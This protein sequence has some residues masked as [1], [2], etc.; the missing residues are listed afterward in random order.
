MFKKNSYNPENQPKAWLFLLPSL[1]IIVLF[2]PFLGDELPKRLI[3]QYGTGGLGK[4][5]ESPQ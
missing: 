4:L 2:A 5:S 1:V 3:D